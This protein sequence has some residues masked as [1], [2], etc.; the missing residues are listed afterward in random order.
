MSFLK[1]IILMKR[2][3]RQGWVRAGVPLTSVESLADHSW[4]TAVLAFIFSIQENQLRSSEY[5]KLDVGK[6]VILAL[7][8]DFAESEY[9]DIDKSIKSIINQEQY[10]VLQKM[11]EEGAINK[12][13]SIFP[14]SGFLEEILK[15]HSSDEYH[16]ARVADLIDLLN[17][18]YDYRE[19][20]W[21]NEEYLEGFRLHALEQL[22]K[23]KNRFLFLEAFLKE[24]KYL[25]NS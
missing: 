14:S 17:Q 6:G 7:F 18:T 15:D 11:L 2:L 8:H 10:N 9:F 19:K 25:I 13:M 3:L 16:L 24:N 4:A 20:N 12:I 5:T 21:I 23:Y 22:Q 1:N